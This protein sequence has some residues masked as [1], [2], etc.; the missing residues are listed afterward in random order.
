MIYLLHALPAMA[1]RQN[2]FLLGTLI[3]ALLAASGLSAYMYFTGTNPFISAQQVSKSLLR[4]A[5]D[6]VP[7]SVDPYSSQPDQRLISDNVFEGLTFTDSLMRPTRQLALSYGNLSPTE[8][9]IK[10]KSGVKFHDGTDLVADDVVRAFNDAKTKGDTEL[11]L[12]L[13]DITAVTA[14]DPSTV[15]IKTREADPLI[16]TKIAAVSIVKPNPNADAPS[17]YIGT[18]P[19]MLTAK[20]DNRLT[21]TRFEGYHDALPQ[22]RDIEVRAIPDKFDRVDDLVTGSIDMLGAVP[23][24]AEQMASLND[25]GF[26]DVRAVPSLE[27]M[28]LM[29]NVTNKGVPDSKF[30]EAI[31]E[32]INTREI[33]SFA[34]GFASPT[35]QFISSGV[36]G[37]DGDL[38][39]KVYNPDAAITFVNKRPLKLTVSVL[40]PVRIL[41]EYI[42]VHL[43]TVGIDVTIDE[44]PSEDVFLDRLKKN[45]MQSY[46]LGWKFDMG[47]SLSFFKT[48]VHTRTGSYGEYNAT[49][50]GSASLNNTIEAAEGELDSAK[51]A[52]L[53]KQ[54]QKSLLDNFVGVPL[55]E[56]KRLYAFKK[57][58]QFEPRLDGIIYFPD[59]TTK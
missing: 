23:T 43:K 27:T 58:L 55:F 1:T 46:I 45:D 22:Y 35:N 31:S 12:S 8:W 40:K 17:P 28:F 4:I 30:R 13:D 11:K 41:A 47:D 37:Y 20:T 42:K 6:K 49:G 50:F 24:A 3:V 5:F 29:M 52:D 16:P 33:A 32:A 2:V 9:E 56:S 39:D 36:T 18:G 34:E 19:Y 38:P 53:I 10:L 26:I 21:F 48:N 54:V 25:A 51:R 44:V 14:T 57:G 7:T 59:I 15:H